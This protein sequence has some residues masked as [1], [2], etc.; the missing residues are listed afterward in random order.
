MSGH[1]NTH[2]HTL[3]HSTSTCVAIFHLTSRVYTTI[4]ESVSAISIMLR[5]C[6]DKL[7][8]PKYN[9]RNGVNTVHKPPC[10]MS[11]TVYDSTE[12][13]QSNPKANCFD[14]ATILLLCVFI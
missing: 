13:I 4:V 14:L 12:L 6:F 3:T 2:T 11:T 8:I 10:L 9:V 5:H 1:K 7:H